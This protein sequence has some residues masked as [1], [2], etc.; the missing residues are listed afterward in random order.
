V[1]I[2]IRSC[3]GFLALVASLAVHPSGVAVAQN[4]GGEPPPDPEEENKPPE[5]KARQ[6]RI[7][8][9]FKTP[10]VKFEKDKIVLVY[11]FESKNQELP[12]DW[13]PAITPNNQRIRWARGLEGTYTSVEDGVIIGDFGEWIHTASFVGDIEMEVDL[14]PISPYKPGNIVAPVFYNEK[15]KRAIGAN[16]GSQ[17]VCL[18][19]RKH[20]K[21]PIPKTERTVT[22]NERH[23]IGYVFDGKKLECRYNGKKQADT[24]T[25]PKFTEG[26]ETG[27][28]G[29]IWSGSVQYFIFKVTIKGKLDPA[30]LAPKL[31]ET[32]SKDKDGPAAKKKE[33][34][35]KK[36]KPADTKESATKK[37]P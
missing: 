6:K 26:F 23:R 25:V 33:A 24:A 1:R 14:L 29:L 4:K 10:Q 19:A 28:A 12:E 5:V 11:N 17:A 3:F 21:P 31:G 8:E 30:W 32:V 27:H 16:E 13:L 9:L 22:A 15:K 7:A 34:E 18:A 36:A 35:P 20:A 37:T 2:R